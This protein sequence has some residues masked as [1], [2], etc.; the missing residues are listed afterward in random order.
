MY[1]STRRIMEEIQNHDS[2]RHTL[3]PRII[4]PQNIIHRLRRRETFGSVKPGTHFHVAREFHQNVFPNFTIIN[5]EKPP[6]FL[7][8]FSPDGQHFIAFSSDQTSLEIYEYQGSSAVAD[9]VEGCKGEYIGHTS[10]RD[11]D[12]I[13]SNVFNRFFKIKFVVNVAQSGEQ[14][15]RECSL[16]TDDGHYVIVG[17]A[18]YIPDDLRPHFY[19]IYT[20]NESVTPNPRSPLEDYSLH[21]VDLQVGR[22]CDTRSFKVDKIFLSHNQ[23][24]YLYKDTFAVLSVQHQTIHIFQLFDGMFINVRTIGRFC[25]EDDDFILSPIFSPGQI[26]VGYRPFRETTINSMKHRLLVFLFRRAKHISDTTKDPYELRK[27]YQ[28]FD[29]VSIYFS[30]QT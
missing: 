12:F 24:L 20:N 13:R 28:Y 3:K 9:L 10:D 29:Q 8:K 23:G 27:F 14:L 18:A 25:Y 22:L 19:E 17:S 26:S 15:N 11:S 6:C 1:T 16:F 30:Y 4:P 21:L 2:C 5:V 7:R